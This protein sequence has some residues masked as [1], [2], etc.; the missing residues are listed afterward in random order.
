MTPPP[1][2]GVIETPPSLDLLS[3]PPC[4]PD[5]AA[6]ASALAAFRNLCRSLWAAAVANCP[7]PK[8]SSSA[9]MTPVPVP[10]A[11]ALW[12]SFR[13]LVLPE[14][15]SCMDAEESPDLSSDLSFWSISGMNY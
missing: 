2:G 6:S 1:D 15:S 14:P 10:G 9:G 8:R 5:P 7:R 3:P 11:S 13:E 12:A 4:T